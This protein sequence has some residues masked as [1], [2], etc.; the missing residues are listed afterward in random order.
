MDKYSELAGYG[1]SVDAADARVNALRLRL[2][3][4]WALIVMLGDIADFDL[5]KSK[6]D[7]VA[8][9]RSVMLIKHK[10][11]AAKQIAKLEKVAKLQDRISYLKRVVSR[12]EA[13]GADASAP[14]R[15]LHNEQ[16]KLASLLG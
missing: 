6:K 8:I 11:T 1:E 7:R 14:L 9:K 3:E 5:I 15:A 12:R 13:R 16:D 4:A 10:R 2:E